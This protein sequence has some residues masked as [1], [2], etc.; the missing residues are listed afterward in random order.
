MLENI[1]TPFAQLVTRWYT[2][3]PDGR[4][5][6]CEAPQELTASNPSAQFK[7]GDRVI[8]KEAGDL[9]GILTSHTTYLDGSERWGVDYWHNG[10]REAINCRPDEI[11]RMQQ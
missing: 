3:G 6:E 9:S 8:L 5:V 1:Q 7:L 10:S 4:Y 11:E 2:I